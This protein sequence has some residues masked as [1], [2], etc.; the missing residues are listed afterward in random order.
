MVVGVPGPLGVPA[1]EQLRPLR[2]GRLDRVDQVGVLGPRA[3]PALRGDHS[4]V[5]PY[6]AAHDVGELGEHRVTADHRD[7]GVEGVVRRHG[8][9]EVISVGR[10]LPPGADLPEPGHLHGT[11]RPDREP[12]R[13]GLEQGTHVEQLIDFL[14]GGHVHEGALAGPQVDPAFGF[15]AVQRLADRLPADPELAGQVGLHHVLAGGQ[16]TADDQVDQRVV[17]RLPQRYR[18]LQRADHRRPHG[19]AFRHVAPS[20]VRLDT[21]GV[22]RRLYAKCDP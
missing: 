17:D 22:Y 3:V 21:F 11:R 8:L 9:A 6:P 2:V 1:G 16:L 13:L 20:P 18:P 4:V 7:L 19:R 5:P 15:H 12:G 14:I 10:R